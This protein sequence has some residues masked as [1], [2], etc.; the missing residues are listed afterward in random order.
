MPKAKPVKRPQWKSANSRTTLKKMN[1]NTVR[2]A[3]NENQRIAD[4]LIA[5]GFEFWDTVC[6]DEYSWDF[7]GYTITFRK[8]VG[9]RV[10]FFSWHWVNDQ[11]IHWTADIRCSLNLRPNVKIH[12]P[13]LINEVTYITA[14]TLS[15]VPTYV[16]FVLRS[17]E[18]V[19]PWVHL[20]PRLPQS[21]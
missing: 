14:E 16:N 11:Y 2:G 6:I 13:Y 12:R 18:A 17:V 15:H 21:T 1:L 10:V 20:A 3:R 19:A 9:D 4:F 7:E 5:N 8:R